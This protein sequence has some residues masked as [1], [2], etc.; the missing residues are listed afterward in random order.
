M[1]TLDSTKR[2]DVLSQAQL[3]LKGSISSQNTVGGSVGTEGTYILGDGTLTSDQKKA[4][5][6]DLNHLR[7]VKLK[8]G[9][10]DATCNET[11]S[12]VPEVENPTLIGLDRCEKEGIYVF[13]VAPPSDLPGFK[14]GGSATSGGQ[15]R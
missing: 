3:V 13:Y 15:V 11:G 5:P 10:P 7:Y 8:R 2:I 6:Y 14:V 9:T 12:F 4:I 1:P